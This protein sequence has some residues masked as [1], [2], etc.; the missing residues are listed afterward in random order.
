VNGMKFLVIGGAG[1]IGCNIVRRL[2]R[3]DYEVAVL[4]DM[5]LGKEENLK[6]LPSKKVSLVIGDVRDASLVEE[7]TKD[8]AGVFHV[9][10]RSSAP[11]FSP[12]PREGIEV[13]LK[14]F[15]NVMDAARRRDFPVVYAS[16]SS[17]YGRCKP[18]HREDMLVMPGS[19]YEYSFYARELATS[20]YAELYGLRVVGLR[21]FSVYGP[22]EEYKG[23]YANNISQFLWG[24]MKGERPVIYGDGTQTRDF[25]FVKDVVEASILAMKSG[26]KGEVVNVGT[27]IATSFNTIIELL[28]KEL[29]TSIKPT[30]VP[31][32]IKNYVMNTQA[33]TAK[34]QRLLTF[35]AKVSLK[36][37]IRRTVEYYRNQK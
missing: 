35:R 1:F 14:G 25:T 28:N 19:F 22:Q 16:T 2:V 24:M 32:P 37:G 18:P 13:N 36:E 5:S 29:G 6:G 15:L 3:E 10:A 33:D 20:L 23:R 7:L 11:M 26:L 30:Y 17:L 9:A 8:V 12:D 27:G 34:A 31:N 4:D 21:Y